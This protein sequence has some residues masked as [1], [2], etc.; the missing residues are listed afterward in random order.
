MGL[1]FI[2]VVE[3]FFVEMEIRLFILFVLMFGGVILIFCLL[4]I[5]VF[6]VFLFLWLDVVSFK[7][8]LL[9]FGNFGESFISRRLVFGYV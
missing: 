5:R 7:E 3:G 4:I 9:L 2:G 8:S 1:I 6:L